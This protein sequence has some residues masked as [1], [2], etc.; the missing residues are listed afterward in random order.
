MGPRHVT[1]VP[2]TAKGYGNRLELTKPPPSLAGMEIRSPY[3]TPCIEP[4]DLHFPLQ[5]LHGPPSVSDFNSVEPC[6]SAQPNADSQV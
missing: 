2:G 5:D 6:V 4:S 3:S 1:V